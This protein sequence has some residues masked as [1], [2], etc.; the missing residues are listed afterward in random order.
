MR[1]V[2]PDAGAAPVL[3]HARDRYPAR[4]RSLCPSAQRDSEMKRERGRGRRCSDQVSADMRPRSLLRSGGE[5]VSSYGDWLATVDGGACTVVPSWQNSLEIEDNG[6]VRASGPVASPS[7][8]APITVM[9]S[10]L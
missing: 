10:L 5:F 4:N 1:S 7:S 3:R 6:T 2:P 8:K 9:P